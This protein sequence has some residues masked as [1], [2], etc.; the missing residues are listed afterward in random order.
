[1]SS[2][3][4]STGYGPDDMGDDEQE[5]EVAGYEYYL[6]DPPDDLI[7][8]EDDDDDAEAAADWAARHPHAAAHDE[9][10]ESVE[11]DDEPTEQNEPA[12][13]AAMHEIRGE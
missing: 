13:Q 1:M 6:E 8:T 9:D 12:E 3:P 5:A 2:D 7:I 4:K 10:E 11:L